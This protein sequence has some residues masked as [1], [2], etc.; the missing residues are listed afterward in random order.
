MYKIVFVS[1]LWSEKGQLQFLKVINFQG[2]NQHFGCF[3][4]KSVVS[5]IYLDLK[6]GYIIR[7]HL[8]TYK[9]E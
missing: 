7:T 8:D 3:W 9:M 5:W 1:T 4:Y 6:F 2:K